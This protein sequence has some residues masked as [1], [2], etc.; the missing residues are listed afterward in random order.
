VLR[1]FLVAA[2]LLGPRFLTAAQHNGS[3]RAAD[4]FIPGAA[5]TARQGGAKVVVYTDATGRYALDLT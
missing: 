2:I 5:V 4:Q 1:S 3:V